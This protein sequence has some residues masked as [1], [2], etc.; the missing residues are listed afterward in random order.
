[1]GR[2]QGSEAGVQLLA[3][4]SWAV[5]DKPLPGQLLRAGDPPPSLSPAGPFSL[6]PERPP[7]A[8]AEPPVVAGGTWG[9]SPRLLEEYFQEFLCKLPQAWGTP[10][11]GDK[12]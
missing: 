7:L 10:Q 12:L 9:A 2:P 11:G 1:M 3:P 6:G 8:T 4:V 5:V